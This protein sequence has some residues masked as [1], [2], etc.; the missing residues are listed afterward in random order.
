MPVPLSPGYLLERT[1]VLPTSSYQ[2]CG[3]DSTKGLKIKA[4]EKFVQLI[5]ARLPVLKQTEAKESERLDLSSAKSS[6]LI[7]LTL[8]ASQ[9]FLIFGHQGM[10]CI[11]KATISKCIGNN[12]IPLQDPHLFQH[13]KTLK[14]PRINI[15]TIFQNS[16]DNEPH[17]HVNILTYDRKNF[18]K[19][20]YK[21]RDHTNFAG[22]F[23]SKITYILHKYVFLEI[24]FLSQIF[25][26]YKFSIKVG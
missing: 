2:Y 17:F 5:E 7:S 24:I 9:K 18:G 6:I 8:I 1:T 16:L 3:R 13:R 22:L 10:T 4:K 19:Y 11:S 15:L 26:Q 21:G 14:S 12:H 25:I 20:C 23:H